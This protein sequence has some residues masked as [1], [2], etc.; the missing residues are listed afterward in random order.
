QSQPLRAHLPKDRWNL[1]VE[2]S[3]RRHGVTPGE[4]NWQLY[5]D[6]DQIVAKLAQLG[7]R[8]FIYVNPF[9]V[10]VPC[11]PA[12]PQNCPLGFIS[13]VAPL[14]VQRVES[15]FRSRRRSASQACSSGKVL[16]QVRILSE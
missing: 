4:L 2:V 14:I 5:P 9:L 12:N 3:G 11:D 6:W 8:I 16:M 15:G 1:A 13:G 7:A 10:P